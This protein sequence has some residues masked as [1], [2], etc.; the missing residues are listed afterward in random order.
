MEKIFPSVAVPI[1]LLKQREKGGLRHFLACQFLK[2]EN[3]SI[4]I[5]CLGNLS[6][7]LTSG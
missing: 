1:K 2:I 6:I 4:S 7:I 5:I 3:I